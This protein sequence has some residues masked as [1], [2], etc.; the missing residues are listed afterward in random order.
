MNEI[1]E[2][3]KSMEYRFER[4]GGDRSSIE[5]PEAKTAAAIQM[6]NAFLNVFIIFGGLLNFRSFNP[7]N[8]II[9]KNHPSISMGFPKNIK[10][11]VGPTN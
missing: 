8:K 1:K 2:L 7:H 4:V 11:D 9:I 10:I 5:P 3:Q 6:V